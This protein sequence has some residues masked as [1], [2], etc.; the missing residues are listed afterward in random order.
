MKSPAASSWKPASPL[1]NT[2]GQQAR[3][4]CKNQLARIVCS[5][6]K[7]ASR[8]SLGKPIGA[9]AWVSELQP[10]RLHGLFRRAVGK[11]QGQ[12]NSR[13]SMILAILGGKQSQRGSDTAIVDNAGLEENTVDLHEAC[14]HRAFN[15]PQT[16]VGLCWRSFARSSAPRSR[17]EVRQE[18]L[19]GESQECARCLPTR[20]PGEARPRRLRMRRRGRCRRLPC[21][22]VVDSWSARRSSQ[23]TTCHS[24]RIGETHRRGL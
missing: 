20:G 14:V 22:V 2:S 19:S 1:L 9:S 18:A 8:R 5:V 13:Q 23:P 3:A 17:V 11:R 12:R 21:E 7:R 24:T 10:F 15:V 6:W 4:S 16:Q